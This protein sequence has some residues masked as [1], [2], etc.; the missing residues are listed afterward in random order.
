MP[1]RPRFFMPGCPLHIIQRGNNRAPCFLHE[2]DYTSYLHFMQEA[3]EHYQV[4][5][6]AFVLMTNHVHLLATP[7]DDIGISRMMQTLGRRYVR[8]FNYTHGRTGTLWEGRYRSSLI[9]S[10]QYLLA[11][12]RYIELNPVR[13][14]M[15]DLPEQYPWS[16]Y[17]HNACGKSASLITPHALY[18]DLGGNSSSR[19]HAYRRLLAQP[20][21]D[22]ELEQIRTA[23]IQ[24][25]P[26]G[27][28][29]FIAALEAKTGIKATPGMRGG[30]RRS[31]GFHG[32]CAD[33]N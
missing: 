25:R 14:G 31:A 11:V 30:D 3:A 26:L 15:V 2:S 20:M 19:V 18:L 4:A 13:A 29:Q 6:H 24:G 21:I 27:G 10:E 32:R 23:S 33:L 17:V 22:A 5:I 7:S 8:R 16:S 12:Y 1:R 9:D 28:R